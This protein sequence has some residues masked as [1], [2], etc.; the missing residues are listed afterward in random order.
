MAGELS[1]AQSVVFLEHFR[2]VPDHRQ[3]G[4]VRYPLDEILL[5]C[6]LAILAGADTIIDIT[7][8]GDDK[9]EL[10]RRFRPFEHGEPAHDH[11]G[12]TLAALDPEAFRYCF[13]AWVSDQIG[14][15]PSAI[16]IDGKAVRRS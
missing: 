9:L 2:N 10:L 6:L 12:D 15:P 14:A 1:S 7:R 5:L 13:V 11:L 8:F 16:A 3:R 4:K